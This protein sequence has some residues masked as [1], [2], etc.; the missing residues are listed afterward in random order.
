MPTE[1]HDLSYG[2]LETSDAAAM[3]RLLATAF[4]AAEPPAV[5]M[6]LSCDELARF[7]GFLA[8]RAVDDG[9]TVVARH[10]SEVVGVVLTDD[11]AA[12]S[13]I[14]LQLISKKF[15][16]ILAMLDTL[17]A[18]Y[19]RG[20]ATVPGECLHLFML[21][22]DARL[23]G[24]GVAQG[25]VQACIDNGRKKGYRRAM[26]EATGAVSQR[27]FRKLGFEERYRVAYQGFRYQGESVFASITAHNGA[28]LMERPL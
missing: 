15:L 18:Q 2:L 14:D 8:P 10:G 22:V 16:P 1:D 6:G 28:A 24:Q 11:F 23:A 17:D 19:R 3:V 4:S 5:A 12:P 26:T 27:V 20:R 9:L 25:L 13:P 7:V 21:A